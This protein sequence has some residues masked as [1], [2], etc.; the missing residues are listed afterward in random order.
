MIGVRASLKVLSKFLESAVGINFKM[1]NASCVTTGFFFQFFWNLIT[2][3][4]S[5]LIKIPSI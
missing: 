4:F 3:N 1:Q 5:L 2:K